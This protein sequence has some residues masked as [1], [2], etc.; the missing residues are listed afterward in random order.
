MAINY[1]IL[2]GEGAKEN[3]TLE[4]ELPDNNEISKV[5]FESILKKK[6]F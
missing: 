5:V 1:R 3:K 6:L 4:L 2:Y